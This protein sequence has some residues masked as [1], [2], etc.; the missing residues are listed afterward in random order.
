MSIFLYSVGLHC[1]CLL[2]HTALL[3]S[4]YLKLCISEFRYFYF[5]K[6]L[7]S[8]PL[9][10]YKKHTFPIPDYQDMSLFLYSVALDC[11]CLL[12]YTALQFSL[13][14]KLCFSEIQYFYF[15]IKLAALTLIWYKK[16]RI[17]KSDDQD[18]SIFLYSSELHCS[19]LLSDTALQFSLYL[20]LCISEFR[21]FY[22]TINVASMPLIGYKNIP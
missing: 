14:L 2:S 11:S 21:Y 17:P 5:K 15:T 20:K 18:M 1:S 16:I 8:L 13:F 7:A 22:F 9:I 3:F 10:R 4:L 6:K 19:F 12:F